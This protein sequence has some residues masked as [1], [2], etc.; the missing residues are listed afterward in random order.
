MV[1]PRR[2]GRVL[3]GRRAVIVFF[4]IGRRLGRHRR[5]ERSSGTDRAVLIGRILAFGTG[6]A[7]VQ[8]AA[9]G[10]AQYLTGLF[11]GNIV[12]D[13]L[14]TGRLLNALEKSEKSDN[15]NWHYVHTI[16]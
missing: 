7:V 4:H 15:M 6:F 12:S 11:P 8:Q 1:V 9:H 2:R 13:L 5:H 3:R 10:I 14:P 16:R